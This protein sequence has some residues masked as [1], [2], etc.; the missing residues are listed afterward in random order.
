MAEGRSTTFLGIH[1]S[2]AP[3]L[4]WK[5]FGLTR[6]LVSWCQA[7]VELW[8]TLERLEAF[9]MPGLLVIGTV[10]SLALH[11]LCVRGLSTHVEPRRALR[12]GPE[13]VI[14]ALP[15]ILQ[16]KEYPH[17]TDERELSVWKIKTPK[18]QR[19]QASCPRSHSSWSCVELR[20]HLKAPDSWPGLCAFGAFLPR[21][22]AD[23]GFLGR[24]PLVQ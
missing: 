17:C 19:S 20:L 11:L 6:L 8:G 2:M 10:T 12:V 18:P 5:R 15:S 3:A 23:R 9:L 22:Q 16:I 13:G 1:Q 21:E 7:S 14:T 4:S 24:Y